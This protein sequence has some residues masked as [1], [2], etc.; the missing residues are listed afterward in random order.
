MR[1]C[2]QCGGVYP[3]AVSVENGITQESKWQLVR[4]GRKVAIKGS[5]GNFLSRCNNCWPGGAYPDSAFV[6]LT[7]P[8]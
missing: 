7:T 4:I 8:K 5:N 2:A 3:S 1:L 6:H